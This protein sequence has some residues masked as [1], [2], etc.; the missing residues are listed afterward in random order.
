MWFSDQQNS[1]EQMKEFSLKDKIAL[2]TGACGLLGKMHCKALKEAGAK[3]IATDVQMSGLDSEWADDVMSMDVTNKDSVEEVKHQ[4]ILDLGRVDVLVNNA[5]MND[6]FENPSLALSMSM[7]EHYPLDMWKHSLDVNMTG[8]FICS[9]VFGTEMARR[10]S[11]NIINI[12]SIYGVVGPDQRLYQD[13]SGH[14]T[15]YKSIAYPATKSGVLGMTRFLA[16]YWGKNGVRVN[17]L[18]PGGVQNQQENWF[19]QNYESRTCLGRMA[20]PDDYSGALVFLASD[21]SKYMTGANLIVDGGWTA[22]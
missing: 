5:A 16:A 22:I 11:G 18:S 1:D 2:V 12:A 19:V 13:A 9:Q 7:F 15:F 21:A 20:N 6:M 8:V 17:A 10:G 14:Q 4:L 3:V